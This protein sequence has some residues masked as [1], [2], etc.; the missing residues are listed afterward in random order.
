[1]PAGDGSLSAWWR[2]PALERFLSDLLD[3]AV[4]YL[5]PGRPPMSRH[6]AADLLAVSDGLDSLD[7][8]S[9]ATTAA[10]A[11]QLSR[12]ERADRL[13]EMNTMAD[14]V[15]EARRCLSSSRT[16][17]G[18]G[19]RTSGSTGRPKFVVQEFDALTREIGSLGSMFADRTRIVSVIPAHHIY[20]FLF[21]VLLPVR[22][23]VEVL[24]ARAHSPPAVRALARPGDLLVAFPGYWQSLAGGGWP[25]DIDGASSG[26]P[27][28]P[29]VAKAVRCDGL[30]RL[31]EV[32]GSTETG[33]IAWRDRD[34]APFRL[35]PHVSR[36]EDEAVRKAV[37][38]AMRR[39]VLPDLV[40]WQGPDLLIPLARRDGAVQVG[41][42]NVYPEAVRAVLLSHPGVFDAEVRLMH[43]V[44]GERLKA[45]IVPKQPAGSAEDLRHDLE[46]LVA[47]RLTPPER[48]RA[49]TFGG[50]VPANPMGKRV[51]WRI[52]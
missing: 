45:F 49:F 41:G 14:W 20:G 13:Q 38:G 16:S 50:A 35:L 29:D 36:D 10:E 17:T 44:E 6:P 1:M 25:D 11:L 37:G 52:A 28:P 30:R 27:C 46:A 32:Y 51:D 24:D 43:P 26:G 15:D 33:G 23:G 31:V 21:T 48:P 5:R 18:I 12:I 3:D 8:F 42:V 19:F 47:Q 34:N 22:I 39:Y 7:R 40:E 9:L 2:G 4:T